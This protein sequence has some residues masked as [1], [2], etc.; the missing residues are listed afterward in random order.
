M[1]TYDFKCKECGEMKDFIFRISEVDLQSP[2][3]D[4]GGFM[5]KTFIPSKWEGQMVLKGDGWP[6]KTIKENAYR[7]NRSAE[8]GRR[9]R[10]AYSKPTLAPNVDG[11]RVDN[12]EDAK[13]LAKD[14]GHN[15]DNFDAKVNN[16][17]KNN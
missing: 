13:K 14:K 9:Q 2:V 7:I 6:G 11:E 3:C 1:P 4:C 10:D 5:I 17:V 15:T 8:M 16:L 12:W